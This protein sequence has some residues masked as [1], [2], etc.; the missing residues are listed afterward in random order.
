MKQKDILLIVVVV[1]VSVVISVVVSKILI[2]SPKNRQQ[3]VEIVQPISPDFATAD[4]KYFNSN[5][6]DPTQRIQI[7]NSSNQ[8]PFNGAGN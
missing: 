5:S 8:K 3:K 6:I 7:G 4:P 2:T 1:I